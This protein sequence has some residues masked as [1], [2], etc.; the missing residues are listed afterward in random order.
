[1]PAFVEVDRLRRFAATNEVYRIFSHTRGSLRQNKVEE[2][3]GRDRSDC[4]DY[5]SS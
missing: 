1:M 3:M 2:P 4:H 5:K